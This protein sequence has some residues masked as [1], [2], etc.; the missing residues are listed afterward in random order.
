MNIYIAQDHNG[1]PLGLILASNQ[2]FAEV[3]FTAA[4]TDHHNIEE[5]DINHEFFKGQ[6]VVFLLSSKEV[7]I[8]SLPNNRTRTMRNWKR[9]RY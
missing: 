7:E 8:S 1:N 3:A 9:G 5:I 6:N 4:G 2:A